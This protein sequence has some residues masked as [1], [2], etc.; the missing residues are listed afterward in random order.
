MK[1]LEQYLIKEFKINHGTCHVMYQQPANEEEIA[2]MMASVNA[3][4]GNSLNS[5]KAVCKEASTN[6]A[7]PIHGEATDEALD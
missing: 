1:D 3:C 7:V 4:V 2:R 6:E 5:N